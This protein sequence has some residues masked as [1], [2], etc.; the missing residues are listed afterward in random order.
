MSYV[1]NVFG[2]SGQVLFGKLF[3]VLST[4]TEFLNEHLCIKSHVEVLLGQSIGAGLLKL[5]EYVP[6][7]HLS[8]F[9]RL[10]EIQSLNTIHILVSSWAIRLT[11]TDNCLT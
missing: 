8:Y 3:S 5:E 4:H 7:S 11:I 6:F 9:T 10:T 1:E 2:L